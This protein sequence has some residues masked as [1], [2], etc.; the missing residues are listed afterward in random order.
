M[1]IHIKSSCLLHAINLKY[2]CILKTGDDFR[3]IGFGSV[4]HFDYS[5]Q[6]SIT[7]FPFLKNELDL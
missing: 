7:F 4:N 1:I 6:L 3:R 5:F 2:G